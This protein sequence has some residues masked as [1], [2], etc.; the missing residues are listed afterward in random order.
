MPKCGENSKQQRK[1]ELSAFA[2]V[3]D[4]VENNGGGGD[5]PIPT[6]RD[7]STSVVRQMETGRTAAASETERERANTKEGG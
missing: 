7:K 3:V 2:V 1:C 6:P 5:R 4:G